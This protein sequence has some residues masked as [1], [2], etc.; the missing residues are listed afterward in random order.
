M[1][2]TTPDPIPD[3][4]FEIQG[5]TYMGDGKGGF[6]PVETI[7]TQHLL[8]DAVVRKILGYAMP[9]SEQIARFKAH[10]Y[11]DIGAH[12]AYLAQEYNAKVGGPKG[13][14]T[15]QTV[16]GLFKVQEKIADHLDFGPELQVAKQLFDECLNEWAADAP[17]EV[18][19]LIID[20]FDTDKE[21]NLNLS[22]IHI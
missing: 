14:K 4:K 18:R 11:E 1:S 6:Q 3:G 15:L 22:L 21:G 8:E 13:N 7:K 12:E 9:L 19:T 20:A 10:C 5:K 17:P 16:D 2:D